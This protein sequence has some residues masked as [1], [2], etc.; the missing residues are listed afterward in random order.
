MPN[1]TPLPLFLVAMAL[2]ASC[3]TAPDQPLADHVHRITTTVTVTDSAIL[4]A[5]TVAIPAFS[6]VVWRN[7]GSQP[8][9]VSIAATVCGQCETVLGFQNAERGVHSVA[10]AP[11]SVAS[12]CFH[13]AGKFPFVAK[14]GATEQHGEIVVGG[15]P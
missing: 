13:K 6:S 2:I 10:I 5:P 15:G 7:R 3:A 4:P 1:H 9:E 11:G 12:L 8:L 14:V